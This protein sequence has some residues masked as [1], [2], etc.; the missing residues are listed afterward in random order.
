[1]E[2]ALAVIFF[3]SLGASLLTFFS[4]FGL[5]TILMPVMAFY[6][7]IKL[8]IAAT[9]IVHFSNNIFKG[10]LLFKSIHKSVFL[11]FAIPAFIGSVA[12]AIL[13]MNTKPFLLFSYSM[14][15]TT[16]TVYIQ[17]LLVA[18]LMVVL[19]I[20]E[21]LPSNYFRFDQ[22]HTVAGGFLTGFTGGFSGMQGALRSS[23]LI[24]LKLT[25][26]EFVATGTAISL[27]IDACRISIYF[28]A[29]KLAYAFTDSYLVLIGVAG[30]IIGATIGKILLKKT[31]FSLIKVITTVCI[32]LFSIMLGMGLLHA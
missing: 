18:I 17:E 15:N 2:T 1:M 30:A 20:M 10:I 14:F 6:F 9:A 25:K 28:V 7:D 31:T 5:G 27:V 23:F 8:A 32:L 16:N 4:G 22:R 19:C 11:K 29:G 21:W 24:Q 26:E 12:G 13:L 3:V